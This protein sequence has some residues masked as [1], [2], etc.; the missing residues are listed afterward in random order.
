MQKILLIFSNF[1][2]NLIFNLIILLQIFLA[3]FIF[4]FAL[5]SIIEG[6]YL[7]KYQ[8]YASQKVFVPHFKLM[9]NLFIFS[10]ITPFP[11]FLSNKKP[12]HSSEILQIV[13]DLHK[14]DKGYVK[15]CKQFPIFRACILLLRKPRF[16][17]VVSSIYTSD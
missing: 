17:Q 16:S 10:P 12:Y 13:I 11:I 14:I 5:N 4:N 2:L 8:H 3:N 7:K 9:K 1:V 6:Q 15:N